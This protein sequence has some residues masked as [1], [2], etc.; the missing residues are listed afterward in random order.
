MLRY[1]CWLLLRGLVGSLWVGSECIG[2]RDKQQQQWRLV[3][4]VAI[5]KGFDVLIPM[6]RD[7]SRQEYLRKYTMLP[8]PPLPRPTLVFLCRG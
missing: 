1:K 3:I 7:V 5:G 6:L 2:G 4:A 8:H